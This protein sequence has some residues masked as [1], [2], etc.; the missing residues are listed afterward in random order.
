MEAVHEFNSEHER[1][2]K[3]AMEQLVASGADEGFLIFE[4]DGGKFVQFAYNPGE[5]L[6]LDL[7][8]AELDD[9]ERKRLARIEGMEAATKTGISYILP[10]GVDTLM[11][12][13]IADRIF[14]DVFL[15]PERY[16]VQATLD[17]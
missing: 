3:A 4:T 5:G 13:R 14:R 15:S 10:I 2:I 6:T 1:H 12:A 7:P 16:R 8:C 17:V 11:G 9:E